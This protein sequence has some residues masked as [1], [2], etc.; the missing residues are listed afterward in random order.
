M[1]FS[2]VTAGLITSCSDNIEPEM[3]AEQKTSGSEEFQEINISINLDSSCPSTRCVDLYD[4]GYRI[5]GV[6]G[7]PNLRGNMNINFGNDQCSNNYNEL[8]LDM[9]ILQNNEVLNRQKILSG[10]SIQN[11]TSNPYITSIVKNQNSVSVTMKFPNDTDPSE[12]ELLLSGAFTAEKEPRAY[13]GGQGT[14]YVYDF[15]QK[16]LQSPQFYNSQISFNPT[17][18]YDLTTV[19]SYTSN[20][21]LDNTFI[22]GGT[23]DLY[24]TYFK[25]QKIAETNDWN[26]INKNIV[27]KRL[28]AEIYVFTQ[29]ENYSIYNTEQN[30]GSSY[31]QAFLT[32]KTDVLDT[33]LLTNSF[34]LR[35][36]K[37]S[38]GPGR[39]FFFP[40]NNTVKLATT[41]NWI[42]SISWYHYRNGF[43]FDYGQRFSA[44][45]NGIN[46]WAFNPITL[47]ATEQPSFPIDINT[48][49]EIKYIM[50][51]LVEEQRSSFQGNEHMTQEDGKHAHWTILP[52]PEGGIQ[53]NKRYV[54]ILKNGFQMWQNTRTQN[55]GL[56]TR[57]DKEISIADSDFVLIEMD[58]D[59]VLPFEIT[60]MPDEI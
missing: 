55:G 49:E 53:A 33:N 47:L 2:I 9:I 17:S 41:L 35:Y 54:Y 23:T 6:D 42:G 18:G 56:Q 4:Y 7:N 40:K 5:S 44:N 34:T 22:Y 32:S 20:S 30:I 24:C 57:S 26:S 38:F 36:T 31:I 11:V 28:N 13:K 10:G 51:S 25:K 37:Y 60:E 1:V 43:E 27:L 19:F 59:E 39:S 14:G 21:I 50:L 8:T 52:L 45:Y 15:Y 16:V 29:Q 46:Y 3:P 58:I 48:N 12:I